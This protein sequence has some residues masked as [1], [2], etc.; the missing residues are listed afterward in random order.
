LGV[1]SQSLFFFV[2]RHAMANR[3]RCTSTDAHLNPT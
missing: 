2:A 3:D 1:G